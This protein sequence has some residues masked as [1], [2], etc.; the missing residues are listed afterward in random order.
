[1]LIARAQIDGVVRHLIRLDEAWVPVRNPFG[2]DLEPVGDAVSLDGAKMLPPCDPTVVLGMAHNGSIAE[3]SIAP[4]AFMKSAR[5]V[6]GDRDPIVVD[7]R[8]GPVVVEAEIALVIGRR[9]RHLTLKDSLACVLG[10]SIA[11]DV[12][13]VGQLPLDSFWTQAKAGDGFTPLGPWIDTDFDPDAALLGLQI[14]NQV[15]AEGSNRSLARTTAEILVYVT[16]HVALGPGDVILMGC[17]GVT[18]EVVPGQ[19]VT[20]KVGGL[21]SLTNSVIESRAGRGSA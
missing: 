8:R 16:E 5:T 19:Q 11:N 1:V 21:G 9:A 18:H 13:G 12:T 4:Q 10:C 14:D 7:G 17:P 20:I 3:R 2:G 15:V 6:V